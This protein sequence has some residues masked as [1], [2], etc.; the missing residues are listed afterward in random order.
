MNCW[1][2]HKQYKQRL[3]RYEGPCETAIQAGGSAPG[4]QNET[5]TPGLSPCYNKIL[6]AKSR[7]PNRG[8]TCGS[9]EGL[10]YFGKRKRSQ[11]KAGYRVKTPQIIVKYN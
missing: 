1:Q 6:G 9:R 2:S 7:V 3:L 11:K 10:T 4:T 5:V 8:F